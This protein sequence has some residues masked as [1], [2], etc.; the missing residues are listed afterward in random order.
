MELR[1]YT[2]AIN[3]IEEESAKEHNDKLAKGEVDYHI[4]P[5][6][7]DEEDA[8]EPFARKLTPQEAVDESRE[9]G[10]AAEVEQ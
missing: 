10:W 3:K 8:E 4:N 1:T 5:V 9:K 7:W 6:Y 2:E